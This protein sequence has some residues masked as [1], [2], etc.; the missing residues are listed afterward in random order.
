M[1][2]NNLSEALQTLAKGKNRPATARIREIFNEIE[3]ALNAGVRRKDIHKALTEN[4]FDGLSFEGFELAIYRIRKER[5]QQTTHFTKSSD[6]CTSAKSVA[7]SVETDK[8]LNPL[9]VL[10]GKPKV[11]EFNPIPPAKIEF[12]L[13]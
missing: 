5:G 10:S 6:F 12:D 7:K 9:H 3:A 13:S 11:G 2:D 4:G 8:K 1:D